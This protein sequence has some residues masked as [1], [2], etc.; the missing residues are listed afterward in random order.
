MGQLERTNTDQG[1]ALREEIQQLRRQ[2]VDLNNQLEL[3]RGEEAKL[4]GQNEQLARDI[5][6]L[7][8]GQ[9]D[10]RQGIDERLRKFE[11]QQV[12]VDGKTFDADPEEKKQYDEAGLNAAHIVAAAVSALGAEAKA[13]PARA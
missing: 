9:K 10:V 11:P 5:S 12:T 8:R 7:Q 3:M 2:L 13:L 1:T 4:R 6:E